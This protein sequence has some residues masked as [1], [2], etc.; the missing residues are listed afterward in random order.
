MEADS[1][2]TFSGGRRPGLWVAAESLLPATPA[3]KPDRWTCRRDVE[4]PP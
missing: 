2:A 1:A 3:G 4:A